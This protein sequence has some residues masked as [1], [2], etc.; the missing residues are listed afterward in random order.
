MHVLLQPISQAMQTELLNGAAVIVEADW[1]KNAIRAAQPRSKTA[2]TKLLFSRL[3][4]T[5]I[6]TE[7]Y[8]VS[9]WF[10]IVQARPENCRQSVR[11]YQLLNYLACCSDL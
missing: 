1:F 8:N 7:Y 4:H 11:L 10:G 6:L 3:I 9:Q 5:L 2:L